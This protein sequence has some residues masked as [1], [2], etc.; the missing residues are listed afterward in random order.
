MASNITFI[1]TTRYSKW[2]KHCHTLVKMHFPDSQHVLI[3][4]LAGWP[5]AWFF[6]ISQLTELTSD[7]FVLIDEDC[8]IVNKDEVEKVIEKMKE[9][10]S[11]LAGVPDAGFALRNFNS[12]AVNPFFLVVDRKQLLK[13]LQYNPSWRY[14]NFKEKYMIGIKDPILGDPNY[15]IFYCLFWAVLENKG[16]ILYLHPKDDYRFA[17]DKN[18]NPATTVHLTPE[19]S[20]MVIHM[21][22]SRVWEL[23]EHFCRY[24]KLEPLLISIIGQETGKSAVNAV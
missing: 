5:E 16:K 19:S 4:G 3:N 20:E 15:E 10:N 1:T 17:D 6:W 8:F 21:W 18:Q 12:I 23:P 7:Y 11:V 2:L 22:Y 14:F 9:T 13:A 24:Q